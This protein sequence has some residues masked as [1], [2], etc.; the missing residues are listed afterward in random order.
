MRIC[1]FDLVVFVSVLKI[2]M[3]CCENVLVMIH[4]S[5]LVSFILGDQHSMRYILQENKKDAMPRYLFA[6]T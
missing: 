5:S 4:L 2:V 3:Y 6:H 1:C